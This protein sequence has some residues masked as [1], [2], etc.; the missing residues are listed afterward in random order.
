ME[1]R[2]R[3]MEGENEKRG[4]GEGDETMRTKNVHPRVAFVITDTLA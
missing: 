3:E 1:I 4:L 2:E